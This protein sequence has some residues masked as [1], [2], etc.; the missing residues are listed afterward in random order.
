[1]HS[2]ARVNQRK[3]HFPNPLHMSIVCSINF[4]KVIIMWRVGSDA[5]IKL[6]GTSS[7]YGYKIISTLT[8]RKPIAQS[9]WKFCVCVAHFSP[10]NIYCPAASLKCQY[11]ILC[12][13]KLLKI[14][15]VLQHFYWLPI[16]VV[17]RVSARE[18]ALV[19]PIIDDCH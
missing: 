1:M 19:N 3:R 9:Q 8:P 13:E 16:T 11:T 4:V 6:I 18:R 17:G 2:T 15:L 5:I 10:H 12:F 7:L 14:F